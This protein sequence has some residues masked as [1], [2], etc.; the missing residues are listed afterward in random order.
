VW[1]RGKR[2]DVEEVAGRLI[3]RDRIP[4]AVRTQQSASSIGDVS[5]G[6]IVDVRWI[7]NELRPVGLI[8]R[9]REPTGRSAAW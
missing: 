7:V 3:G 4:H 5:V 2:V 1:S 6:L 9:R 8:N